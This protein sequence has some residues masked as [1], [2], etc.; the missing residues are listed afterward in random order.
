VG[1]GGVW[2]GY[3]VADPLVGLAIT[4]AILGLVWQA[5]RTVIVRVLD[6]VEPELLQEAQHAA[7]HV[8]GVREVGEVRGRWLGHRLALELNVAVESGLSVSEGH[9]I[10]KEVRHQV[11]HHLRHAAQVLVH[12]DPL[13][14][15]GEA[16]HRVASHSHDGLPVHSHA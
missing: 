10:A 15:V 1:A 8:A 9:A 4:L 5:G 14:E 13:T 6:G 2:L 7:Q 12:V 16:F 11:L 3:P